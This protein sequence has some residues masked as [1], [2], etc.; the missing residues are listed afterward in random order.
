M[1]LYNSNESQARSISATA[2][3]VTTSTPLS[4]TVSPAAATN[5]SIT[6]SAGQ[7]AGATNDITI[8]ALDTYGN[9]VNSG[10]NDYTGA[11]R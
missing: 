6:G 7:I 2:C 8:T 10:T 4:V 5:F 9:T 11:N 3:G 1:V